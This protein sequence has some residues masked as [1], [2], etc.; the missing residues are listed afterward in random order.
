MNKC[1]ACK[2]EIADNKKYCSSSCSNR[3]R[4]LTEEQ[5]KVL[6]DKAK[7]VAT[8][9]YGEFIDVTVKCDRCNKNFFINKREKLKTPDKL[10]CS[11]SCA[12]KRVQLLETKEKIKNTLLLN[13]SCNVYFINCKE[14]NKLH[15]C[16]K[17]TQTLCSK[18]CGIIYI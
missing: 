1:L 17:K 9:K 10:Y 5:R 6:S 8:K 18:K 14:C 7:L 4:I 12:N 3:T 11:K 16:K 2:K 15:T 13:K